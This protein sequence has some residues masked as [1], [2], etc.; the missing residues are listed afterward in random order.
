[1]PIISIKV[2]TCYKT[3]LTG[4]GPNLND[5]SLSCRSNQLSGSFAKGIHP[6]IAVL[7]SR[8]ALAGT[9]G[10][11]HR[12]A[13]QA[14]LQWPWRISRCQPSC[15]YQL[16]GQW[17]SWAA[18]TSVRDIIGCGMLEL[19]DAWVVEALRLMAGRRATPLP[20]LHRIEP[21]TGLDARQLSWH[22]TLAPR[23]KS[24]VH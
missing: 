14:A 24:P 22:L 18:N 15:N 19:K 10:D 4:K 5:T 17:E 23:A 21:G 3:A 9:A 1:M 12:S 13:E 2:L 7:N 16:L 20:A 11:H 6:I 8:A